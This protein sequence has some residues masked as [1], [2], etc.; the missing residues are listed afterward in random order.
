MAIALAILVIGGTL[1]L[2]AWATWY[3]RAAAAA[4]WPPALVA[5]RRDL[6]ARVAA[7]AAAPTPTV[8]VETATPADAPIARAL[9]AGRPAAAL[10]AAEARIGDAPEDGAAHLALARA[11]LAAGQPL[12]AEAAARRA[13]ALGAGGPRL[14]LAL[15]LA[16]YAARAARAPT[17]AGGEP[18]Y[19]PLLS[20]YELFLLELERRRRT[21]ERAAALWLAGLG[22]H[23]VPGEDLLA[24]VVEHVT[25]LADA[26]GRVLDAAEAEPALLEAR[27]HAAR[28]AVKLGLIEPARALFEALADAMGGH[29]EEAAFRTDLAVI[30]DRALPPIV[31]PPPIARGTRSVKLKILP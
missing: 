6:G 1:A 10:A 18:A 28:L 2:A 27:Y 4:G 11:L 14:A 13:E 29:P 7:L 23:A 5:R 25:A 26:L 12:A 19:A 3:V 30:R 9:A 24:V 21:G 15:G 16:G 20:A 31:A 22:E 8:E 17:L